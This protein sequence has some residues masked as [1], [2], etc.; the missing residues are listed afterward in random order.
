VAEA[1]GEMV[2]AKAKTKIPED[3]TA[4]KLSWNSPCETEIR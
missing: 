4:Y 2:E 1:D 3:V